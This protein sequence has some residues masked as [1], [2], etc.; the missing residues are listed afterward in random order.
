M[1]NPLPS[2]PRGDKSPETRRHPQ[3]CSRV[4]R[5]HGHQSQPS[6]EEAARLRVAV[7]AGKDGS[8]PLQARG[9]ATYVRARLAPWPATVTTLILLASVSF[10][11]SATATS[12]AA[13][14]SPASRLAVVQ[15]HTEDHAA[16]LEAYTAHARHLS[17][18]SAVMTKGQLE[19]KAHSPKA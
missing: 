16:I 1:Y 2:G 3:R 18:F 4:R 13:A 17:T 15:R 7:G 6:R 19:D 10:L 11:L 9:R 8:E 14:N 12:S 5:P